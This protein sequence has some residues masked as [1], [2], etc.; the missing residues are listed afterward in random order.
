MHRGARSFV[1]SLYPFRSIR[2][3][4]GYYH[5]EQASYYANKDGQNPSQRV[6]AMGQPKKRVVV[7]KFLE[8]YFR[9][10]KRTWARLPRTS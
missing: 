2:P 5:S 8:R 1:F 6:D 9:S 10:N 3:R 7:L 4:S